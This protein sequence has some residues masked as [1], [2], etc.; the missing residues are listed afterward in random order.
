MKVVV[1]KVKKLMWIVNKFVISGSL[2]YHGISVLS[3][4]LR[5]HLV[6]AALPGKFDVV[7]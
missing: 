5:V 6:V 1:I 2:R 3:Q 7:C 4:K